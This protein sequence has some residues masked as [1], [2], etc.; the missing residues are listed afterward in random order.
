MRK[1]IL[2]L[3]STGKMGLALSKVFSGDYEV[4]GKNSRDFDAADLGSVRKLVESGKP[5]IVMNTVAFLGI[6]PCEAEPGKAEKLNS[7]YPKFLAELSNE[8]GFM[9]VH[10]STDAVFNDDKK[11][12]YTESDAPNPLNMYGVTKYNGDRFV[13]SIAKRYY[14][15]RI[16]LLFGETRKRMQFVEKMLDKAFKG[17]KVLRISGD[18]ISS[19]TYSMDVARQVKHVIEGSYKS[20]LYHVANA[21]MASLYDLMKEIVNALG[22]KVK[23]ERASY[24]DFSYVGVKNTYTPIR[25]EKLPPVREWGE[26]VKEYCRSIKNNIKAV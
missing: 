6:D 18:I 21:G 16:P 17:D 12:F 10:F 19:P 13:M 22:L 4:I 26:A 24:K 11:D 3:G 5:D 2:L 7:L 1:K 14:V 25:S 8:L 15:F 20:G 23:V 9:L